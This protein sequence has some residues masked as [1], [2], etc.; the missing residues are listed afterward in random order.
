[1]AK[2]RLTEKDIDQLLA[3]YRAERRRLGFQL[4]LVRNTILDLKKAKG[5]ASPTSKKD[6]G[7]S[8]GIVKRGPGRPRKDGSTGAP[9]KKVGRPKK[10][11]RKDRALNEW[12]NAVLAAINSSGRLLPKEDILS[13]VE[14]W[15]R[16]NEPK[17]PQAEVEVFVTRSLQK[18]SGRKKMLGTHHSGLRRGYHYG[19]KD[20]F[21]NSSGKLRRQHYDRLVLNEGAEA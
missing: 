16:K 14:N 7:T 15:A 8:D 21:F 4:D 6:G 1:M 13:Y 19:L 2:K 12:D 17:L 18:L 3:Q 5:Q 9:K 10:R 11:E 20:W